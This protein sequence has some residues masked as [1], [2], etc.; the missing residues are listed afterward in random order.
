MTG[1]YYVSRPAG[2]VDFADYWEPRADPDGVV[3][4]RLTEAERNRYVH[5]NENILQFCRRLQPGHVLDIGCG[6]GWMLE[7]LAI[8]GWQCRGLEESPIACRHRSFPFTW[9]TRWE[10]LRKGRLDV[11]FNVVIANH[12]IEHTNDPEAFIRFIDARLTGDGY[13]ILGTPDFASPC[14]RRFGDNYRLLHDPPHVRL[15]SLESM[16]RFLR[17]HGFRVE[18]VDFPFPERYATPENFARWNNTTKVSP[19]WP[20]NFMTFFARKI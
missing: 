19:P 18:R 11:L 20:G 8:V 10:K 4:D 15:F 13:L 5:D 7:Q 3:R 14:A 17:D 12:I 2:K 16:H 1:S 6:P 9:M